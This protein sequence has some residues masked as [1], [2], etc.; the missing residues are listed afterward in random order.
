MAGSSSLI[1][2]TTGRIC[3]IR[4]SFELP[5][6]RISP[7]ETPSEKAENA[8]VVLSQI[9]VSSSIAASTPQSSRTKST[10]SFEN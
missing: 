8:S 2:A 1:R 7:S 3:R 9:S 10:K 6:S 4:R 5:K